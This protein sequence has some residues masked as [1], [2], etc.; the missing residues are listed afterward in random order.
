MN[1]LLNIT[2]IFCELTDAGRMRFVDGGYFDAEGKVHYY[3]PD[4]QGNIIA[5]VTARG[6]VEQTA[7]YYPYGEPWVEPE[8]G[9]RRLYGGKERLNVGALRPSDFGARYLDTRSGRWNSQDPCSEDF[10][11]LSPYSVCGGD[12]VNYM[13]PDGRRFTKCGDIAASRLLLASAMLFYSTRNI[14]YLQTIKEIAVLYSS[15]Q[16][17]HVGRI[18]TISNSSSTVYN[19][20]M[21][22][23]VARI[24]E[25][26]YADLDILSHEFKHM[27]QFETGSICLAVEEESM[28]SYGNPIAYDHYDEKGA[29][30]RG[31]HFGGV[32]MNLSQIQ[33]NGNY[34]NCLKFQTSAYDCID[35]IPGSK[36]REIDIKF[37]I[38]YQRLSNI[39]RRVFRIYNQTFKP[40]KR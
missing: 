11:P 2:N 17:Y 29:Y 21:E 32:N 23:V 12:P 3:V 40:Q 26:E 37:Y 25:G 34:A 9:N 15:P 27:Y 6:K 4:Y 20:T 10:Y 31:M 33:N 24:N 14:E 30:Q 36:E 19:L 13:D 28:I 8:G 5:D 16:L 39:R 1:C 38:Q 22:A 35:N 18:S 7:S